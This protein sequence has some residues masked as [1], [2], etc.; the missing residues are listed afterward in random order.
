M[1]KSHRA[2]A[3]IFLTIF[4][5]SAIIPI[6]FNS[7]PVTSIS[8][9][10][11]PHALSATDY[12]V[13]VEVFNELQAFN[14]DDFKFTVYNGSD[15]LNGAWVRLFNISTMTLVEDDFTNGNGEVEFFNLPQGT[16]Q[17]NVSHISDTSTP[18]ATGEIVS[19]GPEADVSIRFGNLDWQNNQDDLNATITDIAGNPANNLNFSIIFAGNDSIWAQQE[20]VDGTVYFG[21]IPD[22]DYIWQL[23][24]LFDPTY[25][26][27]LLDWG[28]IQ[29]NGTQMLIHQSIGPLTG[30]PYLYDLEVFAYYETS[31]QPLIGALV[32]VTFKNGTPYDA[33]VTPL[34]GTVVFVDL[35]I[36]FMNWSTSYLGLPIG[37]GEYYYNLTAP[38]SDIRPPTVTSPENQDILLDTENVTITWMLQ[39]EYPASIEVY[40][41]NNLN[42]SVVWTN[43]TYDFV[44]NVTE[45]F[46]SFIVGEYE[47]KLIAYD[48]NFNSAEDLITLRFYENVFPEIQGP[49]DIEF[50]YTETGHSLS[51]NVSDDYL[52]KYTITDNG[53][54]VVSGDIDPDD[55]VITHNLNGLDIAVHNFTL[56]VNDTSG[57]TVYDSVIVTIMLDD[58]TPV[59]VYEPDAI[60][61]NQ[62]EIDIIRNW[63]VTDDFK[64]YYTISVDDLEL[65]H[66]DWETDNIEF[67]FSGFRVGVYEV[68]LTAYDLGGN[69]VQSTV[70][71]TVTQAPQV[72]YLY[73]IAFGS[74]A[75]IAIVVIVWFV[76]YR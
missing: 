58:F 70:V 5:A 12:V 20:V 15:P 24:V 6:G 26:G 11:A 75:V 59:L 57:N 28:T 31:F 40:V 65:V 29:A 46:P 14:D 47:V 72:T 63:T 25:A 8:L 32:N 7:Q 43:T 69:F 60:F 49:A 62:G 76:R 74:I 2:F 33:Q 37:L 52:N 16:Y 30:N 9:V 53:E 56:S 10:D 21:N 67:D 38:S 68:T 54:V 64:D 17:W 55:P 61:Y 51:W 36:A 18:D 39:D 50:Y 34:N 71:V 23:T 1:S 27:Y 35:P 48:Q 22:G 42:V 3:T 41:D 45:A 73:F 13:T 44:F 4:L 66:E 19:D